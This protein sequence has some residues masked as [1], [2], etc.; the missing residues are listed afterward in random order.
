MGKKLYTV[1]IQEITQR[2]KWEETSSH[3]GR[4]AQGD[5]A[6][7]KTEG[8]HPKNNGEKAQRG[9][10]GCRDAENHIERPEQEV[11][12]TQVRS[13]SCREANDGHC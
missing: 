11:V 3:Q 9:K 1:A 8:R 4:W 6:T 7:A 10:N 2:G 5:E 12:T 13:R